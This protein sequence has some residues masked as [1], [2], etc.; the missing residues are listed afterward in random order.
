[1]HTGE[2]PFPCPHCGRRFRQR[3][4]LRSHLRTHTG[5]RPHPCPRC[6]RRFAHRQHLLRHL[7]LHGDTAAEHGQHRG[8]TAAE[9]R[10]DTAPEHRGDRDRDS[11]AEEK[12]LPCPSCDMSLGCQQNP[13]L[14]A[15]P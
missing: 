6:P 1:V 12:P 10:G 14:Q 7:R 11:P 13:G 9:H 4:H 3:I 5:E 2:R 15:G 8:D